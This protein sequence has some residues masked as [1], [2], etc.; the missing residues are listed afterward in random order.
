MNEYQWYKNALPQ[1]EE[2][3]KTKQKKISYLKTIIIS[4][5]SSAIML[6]C[7]SA[8]V[9]PHLK[10]ATT[11]HYAANP[12]GGQ[13]AANLTQTAS[14]AKQCSDSTVYVS[15]SGNV[16]GFFTQRIALG[17]GSGIIISSDG[18]IVT[19]SSVVNSGTDINVTLNNGQKVP[20]MVVGSDSN[21]DIAVLKIDAD[22]LIPAVLGNSESLN[23]GDPVIAVGNPLAPKILN[24]VTYGIISGINYNVDLQKGVTMNLIQTDAKINSGNAGG[25]LFNANSEVIGIV[26]SNVQANGD[27]SLSV[28]INDIKPLLSSFIGVKNE[29]KNND[30]PMIGIT[31]TEENYGIVVETV[32]ENYPAA[33]A[34]IKVGDVIIKADGMPITTV[35]KLNQIRITHKRGDAM[36]VTVFRDGETLDIQIILE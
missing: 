22:G 4:V 29:E 27:I 28:P 34:G 21:M 13:S 6:T 11:I 31:A 32:S 19:G 17:N 5:L 16:G 24:T 9:L 7:F 18:Y 12:E 26:I 15:S 35:E 23:V 3:K 2:Y 33:K 10:P 30:T 8:F 25:G 20:A 1:A 36:T 14:A